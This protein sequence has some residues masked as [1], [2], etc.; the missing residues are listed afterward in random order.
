MLNILAI[1][2]NFLQHPD[3]IETVDFLAY[4]SPPSAASDEASL[5]EWSEMLSVIDEDLKWLLSQNYSQFW[6]QVASNYTP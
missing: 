5:D 6:C 4:S 3:L 2:F 1:S